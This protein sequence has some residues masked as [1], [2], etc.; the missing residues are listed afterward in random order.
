MKKLIAAAAVA[1]VIGMLVFI[2]GAANAGDDGLPPEPAGETENLAPSEQPP[3][4]SV[5][6]G[7]HSI[8]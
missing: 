8:S 3:P 7:P 2:T 6:D 1:A 4:A 5:Y